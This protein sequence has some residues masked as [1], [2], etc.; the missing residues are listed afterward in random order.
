MVDV[1]YG[2]AQAK[3]NVTISSGGY[4]IDE[5]YFTMKFSADVGGKLSVSSFAFH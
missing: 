4:R 3:Y 5:I 1:V 2:G